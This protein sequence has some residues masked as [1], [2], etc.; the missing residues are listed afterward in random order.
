VDLFSVT[1]R[2]IRGGRVFLFCGELDLSS[3]QGL[4]EELVGSPRSLV[5]IDLSQ[6]AFIDSSGLGAIHRA[7][8]RMIKDGGTLVL[9]RPQP[10]V[11]R[12]LQI[13]GLDAWVTDWDPEWT[14]APTAELLPDSVWNRTTPLTE[15]AHVGR[16]EL[17]PISF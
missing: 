3:C 17:K 4:T 16:E 1:S 9:S 10:N 15:V 7:R 5:V 12:V 11:H 8:Q 14:E 6:L 13:T 2:D